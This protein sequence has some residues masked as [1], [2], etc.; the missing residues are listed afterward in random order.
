M[1]KIPNAIQGI[2]WL[3]HPN[4]KW[5]FSTHLLFSFLVAF[6]FCIVHSLYIIR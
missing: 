5:I 3:G 4:A 1:T 6:N 2:H